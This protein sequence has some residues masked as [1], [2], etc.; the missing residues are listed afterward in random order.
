MT[1]PNLTLRIDELV[2]HGV[3]LGDRYRVADAL[4]RELTRL[5]EERGVPPPLL[6][7]RAIERL[8]LGSIEVAPGA[9]PA[10]IGEQ[11]A[12]VIYGGLSR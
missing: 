6:E 4:Q 2:L 8:D 3:A 5:L 12:R 7:G 10:A 9:G 1:R 11:V